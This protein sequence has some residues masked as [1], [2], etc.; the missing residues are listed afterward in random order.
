MIVYS[1]VIQQEPSNT[2]YVPTNTVS[3]SL[4]Q[5]YENDIAGKFIQLSGHDLSYTNRDIA[6]CAKYVFSNG[7]YGLIIREN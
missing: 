5:T 4:L 3:V 7:G 1:D 6:E 2:L